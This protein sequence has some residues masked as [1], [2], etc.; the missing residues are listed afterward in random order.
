VSDDRSVAVYD[1]GTTSY[2]EVHRLQRRLQSQRR[3]GAGTD[4]LI[5]TEHRPVLTLGRSHPN[6]DLRVGE[7]VIRNYGIEIQQTERGGDITYHGPGQLVAYG[8]I[9][10]KRWNCPVLDYV[11]GLEET[12]I[13]VLADWGITGSRVPKARGVW[14]EGRKVAS[15][16]LNVR[17]WVTMHGIALNIDPDMSHFDLINPCG[18]ADVEM[19]SLTAEMHKQVAMPEVKESFIFHF[20]RVFSCKTSMMELGQRAAT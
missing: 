18:M 12:V 14:V 11:D 6:P 3:E 13:G 8:I 15:L 4:T 10:L 5:L 20:A 16:G 2:A 7:D 17:R 9:D 19:T 1:L